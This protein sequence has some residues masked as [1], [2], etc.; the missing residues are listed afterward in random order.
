MNTIKQLS[1]QAI[2]L[3]KKLI[4]IRS[5]SG[6]EDQTALLIS[7]VMGEFGFTPQRK[8]NNIWAP[9]GEIAPNKPTLLLNSHHDTVKASSKWAKDPFTPTIDDN[10][11]FGL[12]SN[13]A[14]GPLVSLLATFVYLSKKEQPFNLVFL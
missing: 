12:G 6:E 2:E 9:S 13:D 8:G 5:Y 10:K 7:N 1:E 11:L 3:L 14:G 4:S